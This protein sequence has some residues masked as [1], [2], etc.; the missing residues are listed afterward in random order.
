MLADQLI[1][2]FP[3]D[4]QA[5]VAEAFLRINGRTA[6]RSELKE[7]RSLMRAE[8]KALADAPG[9]ASDLLGIG[10]H[11]V[12]SLDAVE[13]AATTLAVSTIFNLDEAVTY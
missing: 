1:S 6:T 7:L 4:P 10:E 2:D 8:R 3:D 9:R 12:T 5:R 13:L 11:P